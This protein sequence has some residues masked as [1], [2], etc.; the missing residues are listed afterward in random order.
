[1]L[2][3]EQGHITADKD[4][5]TLTMYY[6]TQREYVAG[7]KITKDT[8][9]VQTYYGILKQAVINYCDKALLP[10]EEDIKVLLERLETLTEA[11]NSLNL[12]Q[13]QRA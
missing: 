7:R 8:T 11:I 12:E 10:V 1:M 2:K 4:C 13:I 3:F 6:P 5:W 9:E